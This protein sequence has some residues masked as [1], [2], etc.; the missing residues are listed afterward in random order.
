MNLTGTTL[1]FPVRPD[2]R[3]TMSGVVGRGEIIAQAI[4]DIVETRR[5]ERVMLPDYGIDD[6]V[7]EVQDASFAIRLAAHL[8]GQILKYIPLVKN[9]EVQAA[10]DEDGRATVEVRYTEVGQVNAPRNLV[11]PVWRLQQGAI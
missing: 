1:S 3:G 5:G 2:V 7:F 10:T 8:E 4:A 11:F 9:L 6:F